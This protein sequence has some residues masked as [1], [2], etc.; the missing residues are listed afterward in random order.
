MGAAHP[1]VPIFCVTPIYSTKEENEPDYKKRSE[2]L[3]ALMRQ[4]ATH[5]REAGD[6]L[7]FVVEGLELFG[8]ADKDKLADPAH[9]NDEGNDLMAQ[10]LT[11]LIE[12]AVPGLHRPRSSVGTAK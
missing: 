6:K 11:P 9:P 1:E 7:M 2:D 4:A 8:A 12:K 5:R 3:R 10:R